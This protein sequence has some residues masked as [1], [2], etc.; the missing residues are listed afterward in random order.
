M[1]DLI[2]KIVFA[3]DNPNSGKTTSVGFIPPLRNRDLGLVKICDA[4]GVDKNYIYI[5]EDILKRH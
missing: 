2:M 1:E 5:S 3:N 4:D